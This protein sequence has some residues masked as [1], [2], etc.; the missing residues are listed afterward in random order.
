MTDARHAARR[1]AIALTLLFLATAGGRITASDEY[2]MYRLTESLVT[3]GAVWVEAG[4]A[5]RGP[6]GRL[7][8]KAG[9]GQALAAAPFFA[10]GKLA[11]MPFARSSDR[12][13]M[14]MS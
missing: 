4:N 1:I 14:R 5:E 11:A 9:I 7:Y 8:P 2:T 3:R 6:D 10:A 12:N 13:P